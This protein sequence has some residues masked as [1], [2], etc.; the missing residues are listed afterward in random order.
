[1]APVL[2]KLEKDL[3]KAEKDAKAAID[4]LRRLGRQAAVYWFNGDRLESYG[5]PAMVSVSIDDEAVQNHPQFHENSESVGYAKLPSPPPNLLKMKYKECKEFLNQWMEKFLTYFP[6]YGNEDRRPTWWPTEW[7]SPHKQGTKKVDMVKIIAALYLHYEG[8][9]L[10]L[11]PGVS[12][13]PPQ[14]TDN[15]ES[16]DVED[17]IDVVTVDTQVHQPS[18]TWVNDEQ[19]PDEPVSSAMTPVSSV[20]WADTPMPTAPTAVA[21]N[22]HDVPSTSHAPEPEVA[23]SKLQQ[24]QNAKRELN[25][26]KANAL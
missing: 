5:N 18:L 4:K 24:M 8:I 22:Q 6:G 19:L 15:P 7:K 25:A 3:I 11:P 14:T 9:A 26:R 12:L 20:I 21:V 16:M 1:M 17:D 10:E 23:L 2:S 13:P